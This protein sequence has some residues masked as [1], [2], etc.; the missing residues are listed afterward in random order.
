MGASLAHIAL[1]AL[2]A[3]AVFLP[4]YFVW[5]PDVLFE[6]AGGKDLFFLI[7]GV[8]VT[9]GP[10]I[11]L[12]IFRPGKRGLLFDLVVIALL[13]TAAL[14]YGVSVLFE[15]RPAYI[16]YVKDRYEIVRANS[17]PE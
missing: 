11:T 15:A 4:I 12:V 10:L 5:Y 6:S 8:D 1:S 2:I 17:F 7:V 3:F 14:A 9:L 13:Q 16:A